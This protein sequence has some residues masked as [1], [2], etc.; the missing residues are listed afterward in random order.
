MTARK[1]MAVLMVLCISIFALAGCGNDKKAEEAKEAAVTVDN[2]G[3]EVTVKGVPQ[4]ILTL[5]PNVTEL[6]VALGLEDKIVGTS[7]NNHSRGPLPEYADKVQKLKEL[8]HGEA[9]NEA[10]KTSGASFIYGIDWEFGEEGLN[11]DE[12]KDF[13]ITTYVNSAKTLDDQYKEIRDIG[14]IFHVEDKADSFIKDQQ[15]RIAKVE[16]KTQGKT[17]VKVLVYDSGNNGI[18]TASG[19]N[20]ETILIN[21]AGGE[22]IFNDKKDKEWMTV[23]Y[24]EAIKRN[25]DVILI[26]DYDTPSVEEKIAEIKANPVLSQ[27][28]AVKNNRF[29]VISLESVLPGDRMAYTVE[30]LYG[31]FHDKSNQN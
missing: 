7:L 22:N 13:G 30:K 17:P 5:G 18:F 28:P 2:Y 25:P 26:H 12:L 31:Q 6:M 14:K 19:S 27:L 24:E 11:R 3:K 21:K 16:S 15:E 20:F 8:T 1:L 9:T 29:A 23:S 10:V 4:K